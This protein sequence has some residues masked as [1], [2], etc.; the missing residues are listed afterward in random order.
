MSNKRVAVIGTGF[1]GLAHIDALRRLPDIDLVA[2]CDASQPH[3]HARQLKIPHAFTD[4]KEMIRSLRPDA[5]H[6]TSPNYLHF[7]MALFAIRKKVHVLCEKPFTLTVRE[8]EQLALEANQNQVSGS[9]NYHNRFYPMTRQMKAMVDT[10]QVGDLISVTGSYRQDWLLYPTDF[11]WRILSKFSGST[12]IVGDI[13]SHW[14]D[15]AQYVTGQKIVAVMADFHTVYPRRAQIDESGNT[16]QI[17]VDT[18]DMAAFLC[19]FENGALGSCFVSAMV[20]GKKNQTQLLIA[21]KDGSMEW[22]TEKNLNDLWLGFRSQPNQIL[23][24]DPNLLAPEA[25]SLSGYPGGHVEGYPDAFVNHFRHF[26][27]TLDRPDLPVEYCSFDQG[28]REM[29]L[30]DAIHAS[31]RQGKWIEVP[32]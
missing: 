9:I 4:Y 20:A 13:G 5:V 18:E 10:G 30:I 25:G 14:L 23:T 19:R 32:V 8:A 11:N 2:L 17:E 6:I 1:M 16:D 27:Q 28:V 31:S 26:Y 3:L 15:L 22:D 29:K 12:R 7:E 21:G 24:K